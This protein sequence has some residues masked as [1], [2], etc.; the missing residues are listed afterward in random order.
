MPSLAVLR[1]L[2]RELTTT[3]RCGRTPEPSLLMDDPDQ[4]AAFVHAGREGGVMSPLYLYHCA[5]CCE[6]IKAG[7]QVLD[8]ACGPA[9]QLAMV[10]RLNPAARFT[11]IDLSA[12]MLEQADALV[13]SQGLTNV[14]FQ[15]GDMM[16]LAAFPDAT[17]DCVISTMSLHHLPD[18]PSLARTMAEIARVLRPGGGLYLVDFGRLKAKRSIAYFAEQYQDRQPALFTLDYA[19]SLNAAFT[20]DDF[21]RAGRPLTGRARLYSTFLAP[22][23]VAFKSPGRCGA[24]PVVRA[25]LRERKAALPACHLRDLDDLSGFF[26]MGGLTASLLR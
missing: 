7:D 6:V 24:D 18:L 10:A 22:F 8:L 3:E 19:N 20:R 9:N 16:D 23:L 17:V 2:A 15:A 4:V 21:R 5:H 14:S 12:P 26:R 1:V 25:R 13:R 11:G